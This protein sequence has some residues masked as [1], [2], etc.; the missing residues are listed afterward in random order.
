MGALGFSQG[1]RVVGGLLADQ[2]ARE[3]LGRAKRMNLKFGV[4][5]NGSRRPMGSE[6]QTGRLI[7]CCLSESAHGGCLAV[8][9]NATILSLF[10]ACRLSWR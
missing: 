3:R 1:T 4:L 6:A 2:E 9:F 5:C 10:Q 7:F 8:T